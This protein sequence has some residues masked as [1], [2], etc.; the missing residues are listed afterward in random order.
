MGVQLGDR[1]IARITGKGKAE[2]VTASH[3]VASA[4]GI[5]AHLAPE[6]VS[7]VEELLRERREEVVLEEGNVGASGTDDE[8]S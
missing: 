7:M 2:L 4:R 3:A 1:L 5:F 6:G 8:R